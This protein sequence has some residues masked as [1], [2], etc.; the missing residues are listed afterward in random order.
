MVHL[1]TLVQWHTC[2]TRPFIYIPSYS[3]RST[4]WR[5]ADF[6]KIFFVV[7]LCSKAIEAGTWRMPSSSIISHKI[8]KCLT[9]PRASTPPFKSGY[10]L[11]WYFLL[12]IILILSLSGP[13]IS[14]GNLPKT[15]QY[16]TVFSSTPPSKVA[17][18][19]FYIDFRHIPIQLVV[20]PPFKYALA[21]VPFL[22]HSI[23]MTH[24]LWV[25]II[26][27]VI[28]LVSWKR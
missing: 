15:H 21:N 13:P 2:P 1:V 20:L 27:S 7:R 17:L 8:K 11:Y 18:L 6:S 22:L 23:K 14:R 26:S 5:V 24:S 12:S 25:F 3:L 19:W 4:L 16:F 9:S 10:S 28:L